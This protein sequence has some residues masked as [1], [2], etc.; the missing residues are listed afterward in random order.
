M[1]PLHFL[2]FDRNVKECIFI[3]FISVR[4]IGTIYVFATKPKSEIFIIEFYTGYIRK[5]AF[6]SFVIIFR[7]GGQFCFFIRVALLPTWASHFF[8]LGRDYVPEVVS[9]FMMVEAFWRVMVTSV[10]THLRL[11]G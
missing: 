10:V 3:F 4:S 8:F 7:C 6:F 9:A 1:L 5:L 11:I 2:F